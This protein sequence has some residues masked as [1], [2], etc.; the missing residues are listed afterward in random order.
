MSQH[1]RARTDGDVRMVALPHILMRGFRHR[2]VIVRHD[3]PATSARDLR[4]TRV[5]LTGWPDS[6]NTWTR[7]AL[8]ADG[9]A[10]D[11]AQWVVGRLTNDHPV[12]DRLQGF[13]VPGR[14]FAD[15]DERSLVD[16]LDHGDISAVLTPFMPP[17][18]FE[19]GSPWR[20]LYRDVVGAESA[21]FATEGFV[22]GMHLLGFHSDRI[23]ATTA[24]LISDALSDSQAMWDY[25]RQRYADTSPWLFAALLEATRL[26]ASWN[27][28]G[29]PSNAAMFTEFGRQLELQGIVAQAP[30][31]SELFPL[32]LQEIQ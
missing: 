19:T 15:P 5:G 7:A 13:G 27:H 11:D 20:P 25:K 30:T 31:L 29:L 3:S 18:F 1:W 12:Q 14:V 8:A 23:D 4:G 9:L 28:Q 6:G 32:S 17:G 26:G 21:W 16:L 22:P 10:I 2:C 24:A